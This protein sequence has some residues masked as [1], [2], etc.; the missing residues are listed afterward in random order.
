MQLLGSVGCEGG[1][2]AQITQ[3]LVESDY[4]QI[5]LLVSQATLCLQNLLLVGG[6]RTALPEVHTPPAHSVVT[7][8]KQV[9]ET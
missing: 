8:V 9:H 5:R 4:E 1:M 6:Q 7:S 3:L 2:T